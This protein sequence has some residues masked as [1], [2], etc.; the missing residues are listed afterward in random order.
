MVT[1]RNLLSFTGSLSIVL[2]SPLMAHGQV[3]EKISGEP[4]NPYQVTVDQAN[5]VNSV[6]IPREGNATRFKRSSIPKENIY[7]VR[8]PRDK[9]PEKIPDVPTSKISP[10]LN[11]WFQTKKLSDEVFVIITFQEDQQIPL[12][13]E[14]REGEKRDEVSKERQQAIEKI[15]ATRTESQLRRIKQNKLF[16]SFKIT[17]HFW[18][19]NA[20]VGKIPLGAIRELA[21]SSDIVYIQPVQGGEKPPDAIPNNDVDDARGLIVSDPYFNLGLTQPWIGLLDTGIRPTHILFNSPSNIAWVRDA[22]NGGANCNNTSNPGY[23]PF[24]TFWNHGT[25]TA[26][27]LSGNN[28]LGNAYRGVTGVLVDSWQIYT[29]AGLNSAAAIRA[30]QCGVAAY[31]KVLVGEIQASESE[32]GAI[33][34]AADNAYDAGIIFVSANGNF[35]P[36]DNTVRSPGIAH[37]VLGVGAFATTDQTQYN[38]QGRGPATDGRFKPD[39]QAP[40]NSE[41]ASNVSDTA[42]QVFSG[43]S[44]ATPYASAV[45]MLARNWLRQFG[46]FDNGQTYAFM[47]LYGQKSYPYNNTEGAGKLKMATN[48]WANWGKIVVTNGATIDIPIGIG[49][50]KKNLDAS[51]WWPESASQ[52][53]N[54]VDVHLIDPT[55]VERARGF[56]ALSVFER[57][58]VS[59]AL[60]SGTWKIR[61][62][63]YN[64]PTGGQVVYW[65]SHYQN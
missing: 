54:D 46:T 8:F 11:K 25:S 20:V 30:I 21:Q 6:F 12:L 56:S 26:A 47:I 52:A 64:V 53:H 55:G 65:A 7:Q 4:Y 61:I 17:Q 15:Q 60:A 38:G 5:Q 40:N 2:I 16:S 19:V 24:D 29:N 37:K 62:R 34:T 44:G 36:A 22:V 32:T 1:T 9:E 31:D 49:A 10:V 18:L 57:A 23:N 51:L 43:T 14:L 48:G 35:G 58:R 13:P 45:A 50:T 28:R 33:A 3:T 41:T 42:L 59:G 63:G 27:I 39:I